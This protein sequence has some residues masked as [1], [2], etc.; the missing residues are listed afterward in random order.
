MSPYP[1]P[2]PPQFTVADS[3]HYTEKTA[4]SSMSISGG[5]TRLAA[6]IWSTS[7]PRNLPDWLTIKTHA[8]VEKCRRFYHSRMVIGLENSGFGDGVDCEKASHQI[9][10][11]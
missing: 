8:K 5:L 1:L 4:F 6:P 7:G 11:S 9:R 10:I 2:K 3:N